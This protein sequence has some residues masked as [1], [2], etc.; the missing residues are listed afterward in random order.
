MARELYLSAGLDPAIAHGAPSVAAVVL[1]E[2][3]LQFVPHDDLPGRSLILQDGAYWFIHVRETLSDRQLNHAVAHELGEW[4]LRHRGYLEPDVEALSNSVAAAICVPRPALLAAVGELGED[5]S[6]LS[7]Q[8]QVSESLMVLR[9]AECLGLPTAL[10]TEKVVLT[11][12]EPREWPTTRQGW[13]GLVGRGR[14]HESGLTLR[15]L[16]DAPERLVL[17]F[18][19][20]HAR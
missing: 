16:C 13:A 17:R 8:F 9:L 11:R 14:A 15:N 7:G 18:H 10:I 4:F 20:E 12:G 1:G 2:T 5:V 19:E 3:C 6:A